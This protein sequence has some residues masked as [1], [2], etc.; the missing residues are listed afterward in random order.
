MNVNFSKLGDSDNAV[1]V[2]DSRYPHRILDAWGLV[3]KNI[4]NSYRAADWTVTATGTAPVVASLLPDAKI[5]ISSQ[6]STDFSGDNMQIL[7]SRFK[8]EAGKPLYFGAKLTVSEATQCDLLVGMCGVDTALT[9]ASSTHALAVSAGGAFFS[10]LDGVTAGYF[11]TYSTGSEANSAAAF[12]LDTSAHWYEMYWDGYKLHGYVDGSLIASFGSG[13]TTEVLTPSICFRKG[14]TAA[15]VYTCT[16][17]EFIAIA[18]R[19]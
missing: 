9:A 5:L 2:V 18:V 3:D 17:H 13:V 11:K 12:T 6:A 16:V 10:K 19:G 8:L 7:G 14:D 1:G 4:V 15:T